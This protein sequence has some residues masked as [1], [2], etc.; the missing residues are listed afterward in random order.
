MTSRRLALLLLALALLAVPGSSPSFGYPDAPV[1]II[2]PYAPGG[3]NDT[4]A[5]ELGRELEEFW[6][7]PV[8]VE[9][10]AGANTILATEH[11]SRLEPDGYNILMVTTIFSVN[12]TLV[13][14]L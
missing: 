8:V 3:G 7:K 10:R 5:R 12:P 4:L 13:G 2:V 14:K 1:R 6:G 11:V 9:N